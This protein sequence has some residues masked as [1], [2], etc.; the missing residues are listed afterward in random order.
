MTTTTESKLDTRRR[1]Y[2]RRILSIIKYHAMPHLSR[3]RMLKLT[4]HIVAV[5]GD[6]LTDADLWTVTRLT[7]RGLFD[8]GST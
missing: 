1:N 6:G 7:L 5:N 2:K 8:E 4:D 3:V